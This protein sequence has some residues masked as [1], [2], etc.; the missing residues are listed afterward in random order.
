[1][2]N[3]N[4]GADADTMGDQLPCLDFSGS[5]DS[6]AV[7]WQS[8]C[9]ILTDGIV[10]CFGET[11]DS[12]ELGGD[13]EPEQL[14]L[15]DGFHC[16]LCSSNVKCWGYGDDLGYEDSLDRGVA[17]NDHRHGK[18]LAFFITGERWFA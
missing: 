15:G 13:C 2:G 12:V 18:Q 5:A 17:E 1:M 9:A 7:G 16:A 14:C 11:L 3:V 8:V 6:I 4:I 10:K